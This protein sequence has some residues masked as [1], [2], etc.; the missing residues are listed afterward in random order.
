MGKIFA[1]HG[2]TIKT[3]KDDWMSIMEEFVPVIN[4][5]GYSFKMWRPCRFKAP[6]GQVMIFKANFAPMWLGVNCLPRIDNAPQ[7][8]WCFGLYF[9]AA[10]LASIRGGALTPGHLPDEEVTKICQG[11]RE[12]GWA[13][14][15]EH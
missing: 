9:E 3:Q 13:V 1:T 15:F 5:L 8:E 12:R 11:L 14:T 10:P 4:S 6:W 2:V 7:D